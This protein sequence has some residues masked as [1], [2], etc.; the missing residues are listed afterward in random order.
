LGGNITITGTLAADVTAYVTIVDCAYAAVAA[1]TAFTGGATF[2][3][4]A[5]GLWACYQLCYVTAGTFTIIP[6]VALN[7]TT[8][9]AAIANM[10]TKTANSASL[11]YI[12]IQ[13]TVAA[14]WDSTTDALYGGVGGTPAAATHYYRGYGVMT[15]GV[16][17]RGNGSTDTYKGFE[18]GTNALLNVLGSDIYYKA[19]RS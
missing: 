10:G 6:T 1:G 7:Y 15:G 12:T 9:A 3:V 14:I 18:I 16:T 8:E 19:Y 11:G 4:V 17:A 2:D 5:G 13:S